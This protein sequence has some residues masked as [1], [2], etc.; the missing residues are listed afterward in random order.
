MMPTRLPKAMPRIA[1]GE[2]IEVQGRDCVVRIVYPDLSAFGACQV[3]FNRE[4]PTTRDV[5][6]DGEK[7]VFPE[8]PDLG[9]YGRRGDRFVEQLIRGK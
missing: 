2:W 6:W 9:G 5:A 1:Q 7:W 3:V 4:K 8:R